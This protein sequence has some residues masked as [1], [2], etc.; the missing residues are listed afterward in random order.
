M[1]DGFATVGVVGRKLWI[2]PNWPSEQFACARD[3]CVGLVKG[4]NG[5]FEAEHL[6]A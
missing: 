4:K 1:V 3:I 5:T 2:Q 6:R